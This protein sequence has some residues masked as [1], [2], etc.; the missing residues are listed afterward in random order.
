MPALKEEKILG[1]EYGL[2]ATERELMEIFWETEQRFSFSELLDYVNE[3]LDKKWKK[4]TLSTYLK[5]LQKLDLLGVEIKG[6][7]HIFYPVCTKEE[8]IQRWTQKLVETAF[9]NSLSKFVAAFSGGKLSDDEIQ[10][11]KKLL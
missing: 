8:Y 10:E 1:K 3:K 2:T 11:L 7:I 5:K 6:R 4:Q 9:D